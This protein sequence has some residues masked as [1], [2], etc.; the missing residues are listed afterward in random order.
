MSNEGD[1]AT[2]GTWMR[3]IGWRSVLQQYVETCWNSDYLHLV[4]TTG[5]PFE[6]ILQLFILIYAAS[7]SMALL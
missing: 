7:H 1:V 4:S 2:L 3:C 6:V 5:L